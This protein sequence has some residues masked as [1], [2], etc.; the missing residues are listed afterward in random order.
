MPGL[1]D[2]RPVLPSEQR[3][4]GQNIPAMSRVNI[5]SFTVLMNK[6]SDIITQ[7]L[8]PPGSKC[9]GVAGSWFT[10]VPHLS[11]WET[12]VSMCSDFSHQCLLPK[13]ICGWREQV[14]L[15]LS[16]CVLWGLPRKQF[17]GKGLYWVTVESSVM[18]AMTWVKESREMGPLPTWATIMLLY[19]SSLFT[20]PVGTVLSHTQTPVSHAS[21]WQNAKC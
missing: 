16:L 21:L 11:V 3:W 6:C 15:S 9:P 20:R 10:P 14:S 13:T 1:L 18:K 19:P 17:V 5:L 12:Q 7:S 8:L 2:P 4:P